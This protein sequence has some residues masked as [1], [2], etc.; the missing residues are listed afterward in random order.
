M[1]VKT[2]FDV[3][4]RIL[5][6]FILVLIATTTYAQQ[7]FAH[8]DYEKPKPFFRAFEL[9]VDYIE[10]DI[11]LENGELLVAHEKKQLDPSKTLQSM[12]LKPLSEKVKEGNGTL[13]GVTLMIDL[14]TD[15]VPTLNALVKTLESYPDVTS[16]RG[17]YITISGNYPPPSDWKNY[18][19]FI[20]FDGR[21]N[22]QYTQEQLKRVRLIS[23]S[24]GSVSG[25]NGKGEIPSNEEQK[26]KSVIDHVHNLEKPVRFWGSPD[27]QNA[28]EKLEAIGVDVINTDNVEEVVKVFR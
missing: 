25:W 18:P 23:T 28:W 14:K 19:D 21:P 10:S 16:A 27:F 4:N 24:F 11:F 12:Y 17:L 2:K 9:K 3:M 5:Q 20:T 1:L 15:G 22:V 13:Y 6:V 8:N 7:I 26:L